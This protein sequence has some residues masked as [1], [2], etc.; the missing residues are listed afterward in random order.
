MIEHATILEFLRKYTTDIPVSIQ[1]GVIENILYNQ[2]NF[3]EV[4]FVAKFTSVVPFADILKFE[5]VTSLALQIQ[6]FRLDCRY[7]A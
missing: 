7:D 2:K 1:Q 5:Q 6:K 3:Q 4:T